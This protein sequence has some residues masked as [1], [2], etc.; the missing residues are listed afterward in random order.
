MKHIWAKTAHRLNNKVIFRCNLD[1]NE[2]KI[3]LSANSSFNVFFDD[4][5]VSYGPERTAAGY[6]RI[7]EISIPKGTKQIEV[8]V[9][10]YGISS[11]DRDNQKPFFGAE[12]YKN[13]QLTKDTHDFSAFSSSKYLQRSRKYS[14]Q[15]G[16]IE[17]F[18]LTNIKET[19]LE[20]C[21]VK[22]PIIIKG[23]GDTC[24]YNVIELDY[25]GVHP[26][27]GYDEVTMPNYTKP[28]MD[29]FDLESEFLDVI[30]NGHICY[31]FSLVKEKSGL[32]MFEISASEETEI[33]AIFDEYLMNGKWRFSRSSCSDLIH[34]KLAKGNNKVICSTVYAFKY[35]RILSKIELKAKVSLICIQNDKVLPAK[36]TKD[37]KI[38]EI[39]D[40]AR[41]TFMQNAVDLFTDCPGRERGPYL[42][43][44]YFI[45]RAERYFTGKSDIEKC[46]LENFII[47]KYSEIPNG[48]LP[49]VFPACDKTGTY[50]PNWAMWFVIQLEEYYK[51]TKDDELIAR[52][53]EKV[54]GLVDFFNKYENEFGLLENLPSWVFVEWS[55]AGD[56]EYLECVSFP[57][58]MLYSAM[59]KSIS[60]LYDDKELLNKSKAIKKTI[61]DISFN[62]QLFID[63]AVRK[64]GVLTPINEH[65][66]ETCQY[67]ALFFDIKND[68]DYVNFIKEEFGPLRT[69]QHPEVAR[70]NSFIGN[71]LRFFWL[72]RI[73]ENERIKTECVKYFYKMAELSGTLWENDSPASSC[74]HGF[75]ASIAAILGK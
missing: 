41:N 14:Y 72:D 5:F 55:K 54:Y 53:K 74:N 40:A 49:M 67:Y 61:N 56:P 36:K 6:S 12:I 9:Y 3:L 46:F 48:M 50:I 27:H 10:D 62:G 37:N 69:T 25:S 15:R 35:L 24:D 2:D 66:S 18:D 68:K 57:T 19:K 28:Y 23:V 73:G 38:N 52:A 20:T 75:A 7:R 58:N 59:L 71:Y 70:S 51:N 26:F 64:D 44:G 39:I 63:N 29:K 32:L 17:R 43:D 8:L 21:E 13:N 42:C 65:T 45:A 33:F 1:G 11:F 34:I 60:H 30:K 31:E 47:G 16:F 22:S 4:K